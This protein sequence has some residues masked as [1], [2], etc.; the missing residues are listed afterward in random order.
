MPLLDPASFDESKPLVMGRF[1]TVNGHALAPGEPI[2]ISEDPKERGEVTRDTAVRL[3]S[4]GTFIYAADARPTPVESPQ[5]AARRLLVMHDLDGGW[6]LIS[7]PWLGEGEKVQ[8]KDAAD[9]RFAE[10]IEAGQ[11]ADFDPAAIAAANAT[12]GGTGGDGTDSAGGDGGKPKPSTED[13]VTA[14]VDGNTEKQLRDRID[15]IDQA[16]AAQDPPLPPLGAKRD[17][18]KAD[19]AGLIVA[20][21]GDLDPAAT[22]GAA[23]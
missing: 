21:D 22:G 7:G 1:N 3:W 12:A 10:L 2:T 9:K 17:H 20:A 14:L 5:D 23:A 8:G 19:L 18:D 11:P 4:G 6:Y 16:R 13:R 15:A